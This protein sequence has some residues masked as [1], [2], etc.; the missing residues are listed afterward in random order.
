MVPGMWRQ[1]WSWA[2]SRHLTPLHHRLRACDATKELRE[3]F[4]A[5]N[6]IARAQG[7]ARSEEPH[8]KHGVPIAKAQLS[9]PS[10]TVRSC[11]GIQMP[12]DFSASGDAFTDGALK[13]R[14][15]RAARR[16]GWAWVVADPAG[17]V[18]F[19]LY[20]PCPDPYPTAFRAELR[21]VCELLMVAVPPLTIWVDNQEVLDGWAKGRKWCVASARTAADLWKWFWNK[22]DDIESENIT[23]VKTKGHATEADV[24]AGRSSE[25]E[26]K[27]NDNADHF[28]GRGVEVALHQSPNA[29]EIQSYK[30]AQSWYRWLTL[31]CAHWPKDA[32]PKPRKKNVGKQEGKED[33]KEAARRRQEEAR[34]EEDD[35]AA[36]RRQEEGRAEEDDKEA[37]RRRQEEA[38]AEEDDKKLST[39][40]QEEARAEEDAKEAAKRRRLNSKV[41]VAPPPVMQTPVSLLLSTAASKGLHRSHNLRINGDLIWCN[42]CGSYG[43]GR[44]KELKRACKGAEH[45]KSKASQLSRLRK[46]CHPV[47]GAILSGL[48]SAMSSGNVSKVD[49]K[50]GSKAVGLRGAASSSRS[51]HASRECGGDSSIE[52]ARLLA[53]V[54]CKPTYKRLGYALG[55]LA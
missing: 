21:A 1:K 51:V 8:F 53:S 3:S 45:A 13:G 35:E 19:G 34:V 14:A 4:K 23:L 40:R 11:G 36:R 26:R 39:R 48:R 22:I 47:T 29:Q 31:L 37:V 6:V 46:G 10:H 41:L 30:E 32:D 43:Q 38:R 17:D 20:G 18:T 49:S 9:I 25:F 52:A 15:P 55:K 16:A 44:F 33:D 12:A 50:G 28:A 27:G 54:L 2:S 42:H 5:Q 7:A 24:Q